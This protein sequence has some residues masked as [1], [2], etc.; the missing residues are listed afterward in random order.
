MTC[1]PLRN[2][3]KNSSRNKSALAHQRIDLS[4]EVRVVGHLTQRTTDSGIIGDTHCLK[5]EKER[6]PGEEDHVRLQSGVSGEGER[7]SAD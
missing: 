1:H 7:S 2:F 6:S 3:G 5:E 4:H